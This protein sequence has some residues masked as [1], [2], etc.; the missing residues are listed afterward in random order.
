MHKTALISLLTLVPFC[1]ALPIT[2]ASAAEEA[3]TDTIGP[4]QIEAA[5]KGDKFD[6]CSIT[7]KLDDDIVATFVK[8]GD[9]LTLE[10]SSPNWKLD[11]GKSYPVKMTLGPKSFDEDVAAEASSVSF[12]V[13]DDKFAASLRSA[14]ALNVIG[15]GAT[16]RVPLDRS[17]D[18]F[19]RLDQCVTKNERALETNPFVAPARRP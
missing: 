12:A 9:D 2:G 10:L 15:A 19:D 3:K 18:A 11:R 17:S 4:W 7:R 13:K 1:V 16:I 14:N 8:E 6:R 5:F